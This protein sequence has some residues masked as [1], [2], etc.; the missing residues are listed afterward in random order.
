MSCQMACK[1]LL[2]ADGMLKRYPLD[3][4]LQRS[5]HSCAHEAASLLVSFLHAL[6]TK[7]K[8]ETENQRIF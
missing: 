5:A 1:S 8:K 3:G 6:Y 7:K 2:R 4:F